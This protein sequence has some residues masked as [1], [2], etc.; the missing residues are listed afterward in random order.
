MDFKDQF[1]KYP[2]FLEI[3]SEQIFVKKWKDKF[4]MIKVNKT[5]TIFLLDNQSV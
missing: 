4:A 2:F 5:G 3:K 1:V